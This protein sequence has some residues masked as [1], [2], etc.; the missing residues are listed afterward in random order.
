MLRLILNLLFPAR[1]VGCNRMGSYICPN[2]LS[3]APFSSLICP[4]CTKPAIDGRTHPRCITRY[5][6]DGATSFFWYQGAIKKLIRQIKYQWVSDAG[7]SLVNACN[8]SLLPHEIS[9]RN[10]LVIPVPLHGLRKK[11]RG[12]NQAELL[13]SFLAKRWGVVMKSDTLIRIRQTKPQVGLEA[14][15]R[16]E[17][18][19]DAFRVID[20]ET[21]KESFVFLVD[22]VWTTGSTMRECAKVLKQHG[23]KMVFSV[24]IAR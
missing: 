4:Q 21:I 24:T 3:R 15:E 1:C 12:F 18:I 17:N 14:V 10:A 11:W 6:L 20:S 9:S 23:A 22:D 19:K 2:C 5:G 16:S 8:N 13:G 7:A